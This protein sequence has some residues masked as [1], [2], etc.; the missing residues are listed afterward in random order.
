MG[1]PELLFKHED[2]SKRNCACRGCRK[3]LIEFCLVN[4]PT[5]D[6]WDSVEGNP[7]PR[8]PHPSFA[9]DTA[10]YS[11]TDPP[12][13]DLKY[14]RVPVHYWD[15]D[16]NAVIRYKGKSLKFSTATG[17]RS[18]YMIYDSRSGVGIP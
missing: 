12:T 17:R 8:Q 3:F 14:I 2:Y 18:H 5:V 6:E 16:G 4:R 1:I 15:L 11:A 10:A 9:V 7:D 13:L